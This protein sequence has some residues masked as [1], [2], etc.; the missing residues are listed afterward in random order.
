MSNQRIFTKDF[1]DT[2]SNSVDE[3]M[4]RYKDP[5][6][7]WMEYAKE[8]N[9][10][11]A[12]PIEIPRDLCDRMLATVPPVDARKKANFDFEAAKILF[13]AFP[14]LSPLQVAQREIWA[15]LSHCVLMPY[16]RKRWEKIDEEENVSPNYIKEHWLYGQ[17]VVRNWLH[18]LYWSV[19]VTVNR[20][21]DK[22]NK[23][24]YSLT[25]RLFTH[26]NIRSRGV[27]AAPFLMSNRAPL[28]G[29]MNFVTA[30]ESDIFN[31]YMEYR[32]DGCVQ[33]LNNAGGVIDLTVWNQEDFY[34]Y[35]ERCKDVILA[36]QDRKK[37]RKALREQQN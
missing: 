15:F 7:D 14:N 16:M 3:N 13:E 25:Q 1:V 18:G 21:D 27:A 17:G 29:F 32:M 2:L 34:N 37:Q 24:D 31:I 28:I 23:F 22:E 30:H 6:F 12:V 19:Y 35:L 10:L 26:Q 33:L 4:S 5:N 36:I 9:G 8:Q 20:E 11:H